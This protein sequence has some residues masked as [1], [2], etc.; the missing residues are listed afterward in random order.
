MRMNYCNRKHWLSNAIRNYIR[1]KNK[2]YPKK[3][4]NIP[5]VKNL[6]VYKSY[7]NKFEYVIKYT[8]KKYFRDL[9]VA[10][11]ENTRKLWPI[12]LYDK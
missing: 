7:R 5:S 6:T 3:Q 12:L 1:Y 11:K 8:E 2:L 9:I 10:H 4:K